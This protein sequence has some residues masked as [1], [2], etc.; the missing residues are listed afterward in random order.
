MCPEDIFGDHFGRQTPNSTRYSG[1]RNI[2]V[3]VSRNSIPIWEASRKSIKYR[4]FAN[5][6]VI[7]KNEVAISH[8]RDQ[9]HRDSSSFGISRGDGS[10]ALVFGGHSNKFHDSLNIATMG[11]QLLIVSIF[12]GRTR[13][14]ASVVLPERGTEGAFRNGT[15]L[16]RTGTSRK[17]CCGSNDHTHKYQRTVQRNQ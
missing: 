7:F 14:S 9:H 17:P 4:K 11:R 12:P 6:R 3:R 1:S 8:S 15:G 2:P 16:L 10:A 5:R 13:W